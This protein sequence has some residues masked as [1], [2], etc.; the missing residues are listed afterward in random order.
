M[1]FLTEIIFR[2]LIVNTLGLYSRY[3]FFKI[4]GRKKSIKQLTVNENIKNDNLSQG[5][6]NALIGLIVFCLISITIA[7]I[8]FSN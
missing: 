5:L 8:V 2:W 1:E 6:Y 3:V 4:I 7:Y